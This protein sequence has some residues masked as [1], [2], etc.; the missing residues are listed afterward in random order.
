MAIVTTDDKHY[1]DIAAKIR[2]KAETDTSYQPS[3]M[4]AGVEAV[5]AKGYDNGHTEG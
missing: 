5:H 2:E 3:E 4:A 1:S